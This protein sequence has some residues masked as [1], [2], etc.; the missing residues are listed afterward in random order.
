MNWRGSVAPDLMAILRRSLFIL[1]A[2][3]VVTAWFSNTFY[4]PDEHYQILEFM[5]HK[6]GITSAQDLPWEFEARIRPWLQPFLYYLITWPLMALGVTDMFAITFILRLVTG[7]F[8]VFA[9]AV[10]A[11]AILDT[12][13][14]EAQQRAFARYLPLTFLSAPLRKLCRP[15]SPPSRWR[16][17]CGEHRPASWRWPGCCAGW[18]S[19]HGIR[20]RCWAWASSPGWR[21]LPVPG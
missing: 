4:F 2:V 11:R 20:Q 1:T 3:T 13:K 19:R 21:S 18:P 5:G 16:W 8:S 10:F 7:L 14:D 9:L 17:C 15:P 12:L 6:L